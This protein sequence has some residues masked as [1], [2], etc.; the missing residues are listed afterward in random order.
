[1]L[2]GRLNGQRPDAEQPLPLSDRQLHVRLQPAGSEDRLGNLRDELTDYGSN[3]PRP[4]AGVT[5]P[6]SKDV[7]DPGGRSIQST[8]ELWPG[9]LALA[10]ML[11]LTE[12]MLRKGKSLFARS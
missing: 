5:I 11:N 2:V 3:D 6:N 8:M 1:M 12:L 4:P 9:L 10:V 7:F